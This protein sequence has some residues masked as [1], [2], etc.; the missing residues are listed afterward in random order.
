MLAIRA[1]AFCQPRAAGARQTSRRATSRVPVALPH[2]AFIAPAEPPAVP[3]ARQEAKGERLTVLLS[4][5]L[6]AQASSRRRLRGAGAGALTQSPALQRGAGGPAQ[7]SCMPWGTCYA[8]GS[9]PLHAGQPLAV[10]VTTPALPAPCRPPTDAPP[11]LAAAAQA[12][13]RRFEQLAGRTAMIAAAVALASELAMPST[14]GVFGWTA[15]SGL[16]AQLAALGTF[17]LCCSGAQGG[18]GVSPLQLRPK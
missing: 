7:H 1:S 9:P 15:S 8:L 2:H 17:M 13:T 16:A 4:D 12:L 5:L 3:L 14:S 11:L 6:E 10:A 18:G